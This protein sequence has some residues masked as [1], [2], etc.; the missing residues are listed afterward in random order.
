[1]PRTTKSRNELPREA[2]NSPTLNEFK[3]KHSVN[4]FKDKHFVNE[5]KDKHFDYLFSCKPTMCLLIILGTR[6]R[7]IGLDWFRGSSTMDLRKCAND[8]TI[9]IYCVI[10][11]FYNNN[12]I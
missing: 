12:F 8:R 7:S 10:I 9:I 2:V 11:I 6:E 1:M 5:F 3:D 4:E